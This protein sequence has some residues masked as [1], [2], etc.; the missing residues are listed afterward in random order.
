[1]AATEFSIQLASPLDAPVLGKV[2]GDSFLTDRH[3]QMKGL[4]KDPYN[5]EKSMAADIPRQAT[6][7]NIVLLKAVDNVS[8]EIAGWVSWGFR[9]FTNEQIAD[10]RPGVV[11]PTVKTAPEPPAEGKKIPATN[12]LV[13]AE[14]DAIED[15]PIKQLETMTDADLKDWMDK[16]MPDGARCMFVISLCVAP[17]WQ[18]QGVGSALLQWG[19]DRADAAGVFMWVHSS[20][21]AWRMYGKHGFETIGTLDIDLDQYAPAPSSD[22]EGRW[23]HYMFRYM[24]RVPHVS[25]E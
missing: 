4:G 20:A 2:S 22:N 18:S 8:G 24:K 13:K 3:T 11:I 23:G 7:P 15:D 19:T 25:Q 6:S 17:K 9:G 14:T 1:M 21:D 10:I 16:L 5:L 12:N